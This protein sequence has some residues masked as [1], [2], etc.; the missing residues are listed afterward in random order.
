MKNSDYLTMMLNALELVIKKHD[1]QKRR[2]VPCGSLDAGLPYVIHPVRV[3]RK[4]IVSKQYYVATVA[5]LHDVVE[6]TD[7]TI[8]H[9]NELFS[10]EVAKD[11]DIL[12]RKS[13]Q[14]YMEY[15]NIVSNNA[16]TKPIKIEDIMDNMNSFKVKKGPLYDK[17][18]EALAY[19]VWGKFTQDDD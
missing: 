1:G 7:L 6:D 12:T 8:E 19:L 18:S 3:A 4:F 15:L 17:Y 16:V 2:N 11:V 14:D 13:G 10:D 9:L 5:L